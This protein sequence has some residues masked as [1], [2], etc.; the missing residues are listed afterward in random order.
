MIKQ[1]QGVQLEFRLFLQIWTSVKLVPSHVTH[2]L[3]A[4]TFLDHTAAGVEPVTL[5]T[6]GLSVKVKFALHFLVRIR[7]LGWIEPLSTEKKILGDNVHNLVQGFRSW[8]E[9]QSWANF[10]SLRS[11]FC[12]GTCFSKILRTFRPRIAS[13]QTGVRLFWKADLLTCI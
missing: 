8:E 4:W 5:A 9:K 3:L 6:G 10:G 7:W 1:W 12:P 2:V 11:C 13:C